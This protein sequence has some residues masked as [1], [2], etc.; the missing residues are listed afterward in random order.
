M[1]DLFRFWAQ[2]KPSDRIHP[3]DRETFARMSP[4]HH[5]FELKC[6]PGSF[7]GRL[8]TAPVVMLYLS[9]GFREA[10]LADAKSK[11]GREHHALKLRGNEPLR[12]N[13]PGHKW[14]EQRTKKFAPY[15]VVQ[16]KVAFLNIGAYHS[17]SV[18]SY[19]SLLALPSSRVAVEWAQSVLFPQ[20]ESG[21]R[22]VICMRAASWWGLEVGRSYGKGLFA[23]HVIRSGFLKKNPENDRLIKLVRDR[24]SATR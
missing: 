14:V 10:D 22:I 8:K 12:A 18:K 1:T 9:P 13:G 4:E 7:S 16:H 2:C 19:S 21:E 6:L 23:P 20:A 5:G 17:R 11:S 15:A 24:L 3:A